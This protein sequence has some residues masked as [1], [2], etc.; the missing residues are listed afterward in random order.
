MEALL[1]KLNTIP[2]SAE[3]AARVDKV[4]SNIDWES[5]GNNITDIE[6]NMREAAMNLPFILIAAGRAALHHFRNPGHILESGDMLASWGIDEAA[7]KRLLEEPDVYKQNDM[8]MRL[9]RGSKRWS[10]G[11]ALEE[12]ARSL[13]LLNTPEQ[14]AFRSSDEVR[15]FLD[16]PLTMPELLRFLRSMLAPTPSQS[17]TPSVMVA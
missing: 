6:T 16:L 8:L 13:R 3:L 5:F 12:F 17:T 1:K 4:A 9:L 14:L 11:G 10:G 2:E 15:A 7:R